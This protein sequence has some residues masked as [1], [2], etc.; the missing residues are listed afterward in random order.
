M[1]ATESKWIVVVRPRVPEGQTWLEAGHWDTWEKA[2]E[3]ARK[4]MRIAE[5]LEAAVRPLAKREAA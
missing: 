4:L 3:T 2:T 1:A 5:G